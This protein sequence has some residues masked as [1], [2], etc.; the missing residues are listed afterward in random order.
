MQPPGTVVFLSITLLNPCDPSIILVSPP[1]PPSPATA[2][3][4][5]ARELATRMQPSGH[6]RT[7]NLPQF[8]EPLHPRP[9]PFCRFAVAPPPASQDVENFIDLPQ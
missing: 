9:V 1:P 7:T 8:L 4:P 5:Y 6:C 2:L 3:R